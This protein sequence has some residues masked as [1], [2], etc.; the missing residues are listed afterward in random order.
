VESWRTPRDASWTRGDIG[1]IPPF[2]ELEITV[3]KLFLPRK[4]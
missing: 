4:P 1:R 2:E 3:S